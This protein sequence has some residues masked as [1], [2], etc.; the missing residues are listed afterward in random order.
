MLTATTGTTGNLQTGTGATGKALSPVQKLP[1]AASQ[2]LHQYRP[3]FENTSLT[4][5]P[6]AHPYGPTLGI[7]LSAPLSNAHQYCPALGFGSSPPSLYAHQYNPTLGARSLSSIA[8]TKHYNSRLDQG[9][10]EGFR[11]PH[12][13][14]PTAKADVPAAPRNLQHE[15]TG[16]DHSLFE[17][18]KP[19]VQYDILVTP[20]LQQGAG[21]SHDNFALFH[22]ALPEGFQNSPQ[23]NV[24]AVERPA[25][26]HGQARVLSQPFEAASS[27]GFQTQGQAFSPGGSLSVDSLQSLTAPIPDDGTEGVPMR[28]TKEVDCS[29][30]AAE[31]N[32]WHRAMNRH[33]VYRPNGEIRWAEDGTMQWR[34]KEGARWCKF[35][36]PSRKIHN[37]FV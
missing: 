31:R 29:V 19:T 16:L 13:C 20:R 3:A 34:E 21:S 11:N 18:P 5:L 7:G 23:C 1:L 35:S 10:L 32:V 24:A 30:D 36:Q 37:S 9:L 33:G 17:R 2:Y 6:C 12:H 27:A 14:N 22:S 8:Q 28:A 25:T 4:H 15:D 26:H